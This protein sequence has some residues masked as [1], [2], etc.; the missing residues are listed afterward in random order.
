MKFDTQERFSNDPTNLG[1][2]FTHSPKRSHNK[3]TWSQLLTAV[4]EQRVFGHNVHKVG[5]GVW[6]ETY[7]SSP[8]TP[9]L[10]LFTAFN[11][12]VDPQF[13]PVFGRLYFPEVPQR[14][15][16]IKSCK[17]ASDNL[18]RLTPQALRSS[19]SEVRRVLV[20]INRYDVVRDD[21]LILQDVVRA[22]YRAVANQM[23]GKPL[24]VAGEGLYLTHRT[25]LSCMSNPERVNDN[26]LSNALI[27]LR[28]AGVLTLAQDDEMTDEGKRLS[29]TTNTKGKQV[30]NHRI[31]TVH[32]F[33]DAD[34]ERISDHFFI[35]L[36]TR[37]GRSTLAI[38]NDGDILET[39][40]QF[41]DVQSGP[42]FEEVGIVTKLVNA[43]VGS[44]RVICTY[45]LLVSTIE[46][47]G[48]RSHALA[49]KTVDAI[50]S[51]RQI[52]ARK[53]TVKDA[54][55]FGYMLDGLDKLSN[56]TKVIVPIDADALLACISKM[57]GEKANAIKA[58]AD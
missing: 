3:T 30:N 52:S 55:N 53:L 12:L 2:L 6:R 11:Q 20:A 33:V 49:L 1:D 28:L 42:T 13:L 54:A 48:N 51:L 22:V 24:V 5:K 14:D 58:L 21:K 9:H 31:Y 26:K 7:L 38:A 25:I 45:S 46:Q 44:N 56:Q 18:L 41:P 29:T 27:L 35:N 16:Y 43:K 50:L 23:V 34:W 32:N 4:N 8:Q 10:P 36:N 47:L 57:A 40:K 15:G 37:L 17:F 39:Q 19:N